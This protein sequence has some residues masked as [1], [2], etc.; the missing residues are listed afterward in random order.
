[1]EKP[2]GGKT[3]PDTHTEEPDDL[4]VGTVIS[5]TDLH[6]PVPV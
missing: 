5:I 6:P 2:V 1:M 4:W 3:P